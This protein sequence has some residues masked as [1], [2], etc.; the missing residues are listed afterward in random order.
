MEEADQLCTRIGQ[1]HYYGDNECITLS[2][3][4]GIMNYGKLRCLGSQNRLK[5]K[6]GVGYQLQLNCL[7]QKI[8]GCCKPT[9]VYIICYHDNRGES[10]HECQIARCSSFG[11]LQWYSV[12]I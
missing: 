1:C 10:L 4:V 5:T 9:D 3:S 8:E 12:A 7:P 2:L 6:Y 11:N